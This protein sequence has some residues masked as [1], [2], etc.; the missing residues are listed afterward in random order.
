M[1]LQHLLGDIPKQRFVEEY[2]HRQ[3]FSLPNSA[4]PLCDVVS[5]HLLGA[6]L[7][8]GSTDVMVVKAGQ[9]RADVNPQTLEAARSLVAEGHTIL[10]RHAERHDEGLAALAA[11]FE[12]DF[13]AAVDV[14]VYVTPPGQFGFSWHYDA[15][16]VFIV[17]TS[18]RK[19]YS[20]RKNT[21]HPWP[22]VETIPHDMQYPRE[23]MPL[24]RVLLAPGDWLYIPNGYW[25]K[26]EAQD[27]ADA[28]ISLALGVLSPSAIDLFDH[29]RDRLIES[30]VWRSRL[31]I[32][33]DASP[34]RDGACLAQYRELA[35]FLTQDLS[36][37]LTD[38]HFLSSFINR[39]NGETHQRC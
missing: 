15:E 5:W 1:D 30:P 14:H 20:L 18:V 29:L 2:F 11:Q 25:H 13:R 8:R 19:E 24:M 9:Q 23:I 34:Q 4:Q 37:A 26:A 12:H 32:T 17:Q 21:V 6:M 27:G 10:V 38:E 16:D 39:G 31:P 7:G 36:R 3:P 35:Q 22:L 33:G 28:S